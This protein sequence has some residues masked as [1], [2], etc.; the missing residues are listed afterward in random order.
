M[1]VWHHQYRPPHH[2]AQEN[3]AAKTT[4]TE[5]M[6]IKTTEKAGSA[7]KETQPRAP[8][9]DTTVPSSR[10]PP[11]NNAARPINV[12]PS[13]NST[14]HHSF[15]AVPSNPSAP[16]APSTAPRQPTTNPTTPTELAKSVRVA[17]G[18]RV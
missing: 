14:H 7:S 13:S 15:I 8:E 16:S 12:K 4:W 11:F 9:I 17:G 1:L 3:A 10:C 18:S 6:G 5:R 2:D